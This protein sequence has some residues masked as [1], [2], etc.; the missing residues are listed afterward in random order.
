[1]KIPDQTIT[2]RFVVEPSETHT[3]P[4]HSEDLVTPLI[5]TLAARVDTIEEDSERKNSLRALFLAAK[6]DE[7]NPT[8]QDVVVSI[9]FDHL[10]YVKGWSRTS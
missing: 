4:G 7:I 10:G 5:R 1:M 2:V 8:K 6:R 3:S 9:R